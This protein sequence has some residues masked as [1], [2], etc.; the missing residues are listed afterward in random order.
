[1]LPCRIKFKV[2][3]KQGKISTEDNSK[4]TFENSSENIF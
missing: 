2:N 3:S 1:M 4:E